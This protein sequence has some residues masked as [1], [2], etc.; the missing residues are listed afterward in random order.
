LVVPLPSD[1]ELL[2]AAAAARSRAYAPYSGFAVGA[3][4]VGTSGQVYAGA[5]VENAS[6]PLCCCAERVAIYVAVAAG[7]TGIRRVAVVT[8]TEPP[9]NPCGAC[10]QVIFE[11]GPDAEVVVANVA[12][13]SRVISIRELL[14]G[15][16]DGADLRR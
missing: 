9:A 11:L 3:A 14:P 7:E 5:N 2:S 12:G 10:R 8:D 4:V 15:G 1:A 6:F 13:A 16:F